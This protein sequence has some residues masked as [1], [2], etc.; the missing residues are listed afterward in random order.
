MLKCAE[1]NIFLSYVSYL[2]EKCADRVVHRTK[3]STYCEF[4][5]C[6]QLCSFLNASLEQ[7]NAF[8]SFRWK[9]LSKS[10]NEG[11]TL[12]IVCCHHLRK[13]KR[14]LFTVVKFL[15]RGKFHS[16]QSYVHKA[17]FRSHK[18]H[19]RDKR[20]KF[21]ITQFF[22]IINASFYCIEVFISVT[23]IFI[24]ISYFSTEQIVEL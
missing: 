21:E 6:V 7:V 24:N 9:F 5:I 8:R 12:P 15:S 4:Y 14:C 10:R 11:T 2:F 23:G 20:Y 22:A 1:R 18:L 19:F 3:K 16:F 13:N 17:T